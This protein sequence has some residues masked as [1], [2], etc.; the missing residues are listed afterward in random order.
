MKEYM[1]VVIDETKPRAIF[2]D[3]DRQLLYVGTNLVGKGSRIEVYWRTPLNKYF[4]MAETSAF[5]DSLRHELE[6]VL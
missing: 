6:E 4:F 1:V 5:F 3:T 2:V